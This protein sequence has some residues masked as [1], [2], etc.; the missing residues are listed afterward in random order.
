[1][2]KLF[3][4]EYMWMV[5]NHMKCCSTSLIIKEMQIKNKMKYHY[6]AF[7]IVQIKEKLTVM[8]AKEDMEKLVNIEQFSQCL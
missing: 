8:D 5:Y 3:T 7:I 6:I 4:K 2:N 1:M